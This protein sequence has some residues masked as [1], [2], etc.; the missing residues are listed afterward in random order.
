MKEMSDFFSLLTVKLQNYVQINI[1][2]LVASRKY[3][4]ETI[5]LISMSDFSL[6]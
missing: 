1:R 6:G 5:Y 4:K 2:L 3:Y